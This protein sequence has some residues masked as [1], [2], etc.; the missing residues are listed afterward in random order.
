MSGLYN[1]I[2]RLLCGLKNSNKLK[3]IY[4]C[5]ETYDDIIGKEITDLTMLR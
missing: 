3:H 5:I 4:L 1:I 2:C